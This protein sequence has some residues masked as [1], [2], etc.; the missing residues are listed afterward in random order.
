MCGVLK[1]K[2]TISAPNGA[3]DTA[4]VDLN[5]TLQQSL[6]LRG[7]MVGY[8]GPASNAQNAPNL[9][10]SA[11]T[12][13]NLQA[14]AAWAL[15][16]YPVRSVASFSTGGSIT[17]T[18]HL[19]D[20]QLP[21][22]GCSNNW[23]ALNSNVQAQVVLDGNKSG[24]LYYGL[25]ASGVP[26]GPV[27]GC[28]S[29]GVSSGQVN[30]AVTLAH[31]VGHRCGLKHGP[32]GSVGNSA[33]PNYPAYEP[34]DPTNTP[35]ASIG[36]YGLDIS[37]GA[38]WSPKTTKDMMSYC[39]PNWISLYHYG[40]LLNNDALNPQQVCHDDPW[41]ENINQYDPW[42]WLPWRYIPIHRRQVH[43]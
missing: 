9:T 27:V 10:L 25:L 34:Y 31:E 11:P 38:I 13:A 24:W 15:L 17:L 21:N 16:T 1:L 35:Q 4:E 18:T 19:Q 37:T 3:T 36:E 40:R 7:I 12:V 28:E 41:W 6:R 8:N 29:S 43:P 33:D 26:M 14:T 30:A 2:V 42:W 32:C 20:A 5:V 23:L 39:G 22:G